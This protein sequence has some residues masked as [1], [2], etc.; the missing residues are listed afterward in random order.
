MIILLGGSFDPIHKGHLAVAKAVNN[1]FSP[2]EFR[3]LPCGQHAFSKPIQAASFHRLAMLKLALQD[4][5]SIFSIDEQEIKKSEASYTIDTLRKIRSTLSSNQSLAFV[6]GQDALQQLDQW[7]EWTSLL[8]Y[9]HLIVVSRLTKPE[10][11]ASLKS[12]IEAHQSQRIEL[13]KS[14]PAGKIYFLDMSC[15]DISST[16][17]RAELASNQ[18]SEDALPEKV[19]EY[20]R[21]N[22]LYSVRNLVN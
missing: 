1:Y 11:P 9:A 3:F 16:Q 18:I 20:I 15:V 10:M 8:N 22:G 5:T 14:T 13:L 17:L 4:Q 7:K 21:E 2:Q 19:L 6:I 12:Y